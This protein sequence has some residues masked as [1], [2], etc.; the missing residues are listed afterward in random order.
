[1]S[2]VKAARK[3]KRIVQTGSMQRSD[4]K[5]LQAAEYVRNGRLGK[6]KRVLVGLTG[7]NYEE[8]AKPLVAPD[9]APPPE[10]D[11]EFWL[12]PA[13]WRPYNKNRVHYLFRFFWDYSGGQM[14]NWGAH[15]LD[16]AQ[17]ALGKDESGPVAIEGKGEYDSEKRFETPIKF[18]L[19]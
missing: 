18:S 17:W 3:H 13:P 11:Y 8:R 15:H 9:S 2:M 6:I 1:Q 12:G 16:I 5:F 10:L 4:A 19:H 14:T 7:V